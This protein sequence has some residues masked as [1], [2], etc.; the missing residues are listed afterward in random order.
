MLLWRANA[1]AEIVATVSGKLYRG[2]PRDVDNP[3]EI[4]DLVAT[5]DPGAVIELTER[6]EEKAIER[7]LNSDITALRAAFN[8]FQRSVPHCEPQLP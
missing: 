6:Q 7:L 3:D 2:N 5:D 1:E 4:V 8:R